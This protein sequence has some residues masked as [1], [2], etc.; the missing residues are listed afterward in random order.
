MDDRG[1]IRKILN[2]LYKAYGKPR[3]LKLSDPVDE[4]I[5]TVLSQNTNDR[6]SLGAFAILKKSFRSW[7]G[8][9]KTDTARVARLIRHAGLANIKARRIKGVLKEI[10]K[11]ETKITLAPL[12]KMEVAEA[13]QY[14]RTLKGVGPKTAACVLLFSFGKAVMPVDTHIFRVTKRLGLI[15]NNIDIETAHETLT[16]LVPK[17]LIYGFHLGIIEHGRRTC[18]ARNPTCGVCILYSLCKFRRKVQSAKRKTKT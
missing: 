18:R 17:D 8:L 14:L 12:K 10:E 11:R 7:E 2:L 15:R 16:G 5:R 4:L 13:V 6:N 1:R 3:P 9:V